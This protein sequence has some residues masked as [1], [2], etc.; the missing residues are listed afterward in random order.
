MRAP[1]VTIA[2]AAVALAGCS[3][4]TPTGA[5]SPPPTASSTTTASTTALGT[6][7]TE[8][9][10][11]CP[12]TG[13]AA[14][15]DKAAQRFWLCDGGVPVT[16]E[17][18]MTTASAEYGL[19]PVGEYVVTAKEEVACGV[20]GERL[21][22]FVAFYTTPRGNRIAFHE[23]V[24]QDPAT[25]GDLDQRGQSSGCFRVSDADSWEVWE[26]LEIGDPVIVLT[27]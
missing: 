11:G 21:E 6:V 17:L 23:V 14:V 22:R 16:G 18:A 2:L 3:Q 8:T 12:P 20:D 5:I 10:P 27:N 24:L 13:R 1:I 25:L 9:L 19:P 7:V 4:P 15:A 26:F